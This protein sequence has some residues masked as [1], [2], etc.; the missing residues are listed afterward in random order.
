VLKICESKISLNGNIK[1]VTKRI[2]RA[3]KFYWS[4]RDVPEKIKLCYINTPLAYFD[5]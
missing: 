1:E 4:V 5:I 2:Y 3:K